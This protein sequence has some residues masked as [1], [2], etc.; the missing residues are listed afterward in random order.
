MKRILALLRT[1]L[2]VLVPVTRKADEYHERHA[3]RA[4]HE[5]HL[6]RLRRRQ[7]NLKGK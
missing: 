4:L 2:D 5:T 6:A 3:R 7:R 1:W